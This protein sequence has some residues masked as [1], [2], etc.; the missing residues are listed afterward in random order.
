M[1]L[2]NSRGSNLRFVQKFVV[3]KG[4][5]LPLGEIDLLGGK[6]RSEPYLCKPKNPGGTMLAVELD[7]WRMP[8][9]FIA[10]CMT[11]ANTL[12]FSF[13]DFAATVTRGLDPVTG[14]FAG[15]IDCTKARPGAAA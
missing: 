14:N 5:E 7:Y 3:E 11:L 1:K 9:E 10:T 12:V 2:Y 4:I 6:N 13:L 8:S 15:V